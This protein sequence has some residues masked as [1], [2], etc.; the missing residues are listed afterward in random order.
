M[1]AE[2]L[3]ILKQLFT[4]K[5]IGCWDFFSA[6]TKLLHKVVPVFLGAICVTAITHE[7][8]KDKRNA[9]AVSILEKREP[10]TQ[11]GPRSVGSVWESMLVRLIS[12][13]FPMDWCGFDGCYFANAEHTAFFL[14]L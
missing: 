1:A 12:L 10:T 13:V 5:A 14:F 7:C 9:C 4:I 6:T 11:T 3:I 8:R 2:S